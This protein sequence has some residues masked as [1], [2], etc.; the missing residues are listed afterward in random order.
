LRQLTASF[1]VTPLG[2]IVVLLFPIALAVFLLGPRSVQAPALVVAAL[3]LLFVVGGTFSGAR[4][5]WGGGGSPP[6]EAVRSAAAEFRPRAGAG[7]IEQEAD[8]PDAWRKE[9]ERRERHERE[10]TSGGAR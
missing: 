5:R 7:P 2:W 1:R 9:R 6:T 8:D 3:V 4:I 10:Q